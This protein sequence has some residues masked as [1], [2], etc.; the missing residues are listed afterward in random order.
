MVARRNASLAS[1]D[2]VMGC[3]RRLERESLLIFKDCSAA[4]FVKRRQTM[5]E[6]PFFLGFFSVI[7]VSRSFFH[8]LN[9]FS[10]LSP[11]IYKISYTHQKKI[12]GENPPLFCPFVLK[13]RRRDTKR[14]CSL[15]ASE[16]R[17]ATTTKT[18]TFV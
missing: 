4:L 10:C 18:T 6:I 15:R 5:C 1:F 16:T 11:D 9:V 3:C 8:R 17:R 13:R 2:D 14:R 7:Y 12:S